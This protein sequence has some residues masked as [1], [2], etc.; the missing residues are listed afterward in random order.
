MTSRDQ[1]RWA[2]HSW[3]IRHWGQLVRLVITAS[4]VAFAAWVLVQ[5][6]A[7]L[8]AYPI[9][10]N[11][12]PLIASFLV[13]CPGFVL[14]ALTWRR[15]LGCYGIRQSA[16]DDLRIYSYGTVALALPGGIWSIISRSAG[17]QRLGVSPG[18]VAAAS[19]IE[20][21]VIGV[22]SLAVYAVAVVLHPQISLW[23]RPEIGAGFAALV[24]IVIHPRVFTPFSRWL[25]Q[26]TRS[27]SETLLVDFTLRELVSWIFLEAL[28]VLI[29][30]L[31]VLVLLNSLGES[32]ETVI[33]PVIAAW[34]AASAASN[35]FFWLPGTPILRDGVMILVLA[36]SLSLPIALIFAILLRVWAITSLLIIAG[37]IWMFLYLLPAWRGS[38]PAPNR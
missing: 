32:P 18:R 35:L 33:I 38:T 29:G 30:G 12:L 14:A 4:A 13:S 20:T 31:A 15:I 6:S 16:R 21:L 36:P 22:A 37:L 23:Q 11:I 3:L 17:Y 19:V 26:R 25:Q 7:E 2:T 24:L 34:A 28:V 9:R 5:G 10:L 27:G 1:H 8:Q